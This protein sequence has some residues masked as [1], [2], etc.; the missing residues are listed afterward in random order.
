MPGTAGLVALASSL[1]GSANDMTDGGLASGEGRHGDA[2]PTFID[3]HADALPGDE[4]VEGH[5][6]GGRLR[7]P[8]PP[9]PRPPPI[10][11]LQTAGR[12]GSTGR[13]MELATGYG[14]GCRTRYGLSP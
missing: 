13:T 5:P 6:N 2:R 8:P 1:G 10:Q 7:E 3:D 11:R 9:A 4:S 12:E 14:G